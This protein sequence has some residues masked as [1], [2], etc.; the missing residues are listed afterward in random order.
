[1]TESFSYEIPED[2]REYYEWRQKAQ[3][4]GLLHDATLAYYLSDSK[5]LYTIAV[6]GDL[7]TAPIFTYRKWLEPH[8]PLDTPIAGVSPDPI[9]DDYEEDAMLEMVKTI[10]YNDGNFEGESDEYIWNGPVF[11][12]NKA[13]TDTLSFNLVESDYFTVKTAAVKLKDELYRSLYERGVAADAPYLD[14]V[15]H[16]NEIE[17][18]LRDEYYR[19]FEQVLEFHDGPRL[20]GC[21]V[22]S[23]FNTGDGYVVPIETRS[24][25]VSES[26][27]WKNPIPA[28]VLQPAEGEAERLADMDSEDLTILQ[29]HIF[30]EYKGSFLD[31]ENETEGLEALEDVLQT[32]DGKLIYT[33]AGID[34]KQ[35]YLQFYGLLFIDDPEYYEEYI[36]GQDLGGWEAEDVELVSLSDGDRLKELLDRHTMNPYN[37][38]GFAEALFTLRDVYDI[39]LPIDLSRT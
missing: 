31:E 18:P 12:A 38:L 35:T 6:D 17:T 32:D 37:L 10:A 9:V 30:E 25:K 22:V 13:S 36:E 33:S 24:S 26:A 19:N 16:I 8:H 28:G 15:D 2:E 1:M 27:G 23:V 14:V 3:K 21:S 4:N 20:A 34:C 5:H 29:E 7:E 11:A 39:E